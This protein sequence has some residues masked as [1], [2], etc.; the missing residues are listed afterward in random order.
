M[1]GTASCTGFHAAWRRDRTGTRNRPDRREWRL[2]SAAATARIIGSSAAST[3]KPGGLAKRHKTNGGRYQIGD[4]CLEIG[5]SGRVLRDTMRAGDRPDSDRIRDA[6]RR[7]RNPP[8][9]GRQHESP[10]LIER[11]ALP[12]PARCGRAGK[13]RDFGQGAPDRRR[14]GGHGAAGS[15]RCGRCHGENIGQPS[16]EI[17]FVCNVAGFDRPFQ[18]VGVCE[19]TGR[20]RRRQPRHQP[21]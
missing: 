19:S 15:C 6:L 16:L 17:G 3:R 7:R 9:R 4:K 1:S 5:R 18:T 13:V 2:W 14:H 21:E 8:W 20:K 11:F 12:F 10:A